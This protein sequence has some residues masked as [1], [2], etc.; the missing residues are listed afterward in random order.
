MRDIVSAC[1]LYVCKCVSVYGCVCVSECHLLPV[2]FWDGTSSFKVWSILTTAPSLVTPRGDLCVAFHVQRQ[3]I[4]P[5][6]A[7]VTVS[8]LERFRARVLPVVARQFVAAGKAPLAA[9]PRAFVGFFA[10]MRP[11]VRLQV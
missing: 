8:A 3:V 5:G 9:L 7:P 6:K 11:L 4:G 2:T 10:C 1:V